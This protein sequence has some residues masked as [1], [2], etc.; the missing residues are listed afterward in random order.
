VQLF[1]DSIPSSLPHVK[2]GRLRAIAVTTGS[3]QPLLPDL[4]PISD[5]IPGFNISNWNA[6]FLPARTPKSVVDRVFAEVNKA[7]KAPA[8]KE[9]QNAV[10]IDPAGSNSQAEFAAFLRED[11]V[12]WAKIIKDA[13]VTVSP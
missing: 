9:R 2:S 3:R 4:P 10:G 7:I 5:T 6:L 1:F 13:N 11:R 12:R 8:V